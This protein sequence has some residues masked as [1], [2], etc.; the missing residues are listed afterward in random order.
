MKKIYRTYS[1]TE[2]ATLSCE[3]KC[4][5][6]GNDFS[7]EDDLS[8]CETYVINCEECD[9]EFEMYFDVD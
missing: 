9:E 8:P 3:V 5:I 6:C 7:Y 4:P 2:V 1:D